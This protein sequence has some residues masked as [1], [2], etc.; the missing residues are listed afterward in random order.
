MS[1]VPQSIVVNK[2]MSNLSI[3]QG[4]MVPVRLSRTQNK[5][6]LQP[7]IHVQMFVK[8]VTKRTLLFCTDSCEVVIKD[9]QTMSLW[10]SG[11]DPKGCRLRLNKT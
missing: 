11:C 1:R 7:V 10:S 6:R 5:H 2:D 8:Q 4:G 3:L 9:G